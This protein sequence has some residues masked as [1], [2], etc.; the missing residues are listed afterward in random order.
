MIGRMHLRLAGETGD[1]HVTSR[2][3]LCRIGVQVATMIDE[4]GRAGPTQGADGKAVCNEIAGASASDL[5]Q[6]DDADA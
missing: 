6:S 5:A 4:V 3:E 1:D 2:R